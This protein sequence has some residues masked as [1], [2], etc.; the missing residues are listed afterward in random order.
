MEIY[1]A[2]IRGIEGQL[3]RFTAVK[4]VERRNVTLLG[5]AQ[6]VVR[7]GFQRAAKA[8]ETLEGEWSSILSNQGYTIQLSPAETP[9]TSSGLDLPIAIMLL[10]ASILQNLESL[11]SEIERLEKEVEKIGERE[12]RE[13]LKTQLLEEIDS[14]IRQRELIL[15]Y[16]KRLTG[17]KSRYLLIGTL[18]ITTGG[19]LTP[20]YGMFGM[21][22]CAKPGFDVVIPEES[23]VHGALISKARG[24]IRVIIAADLQEVWNVIL[25]LT[26]PRKAS[27][28][29]SQIKEKRL[30]HYVPDLKAIHGVALAKRAMVVA[31]AGGHNIL[32]LGPPGQGKSMLAQAATKLLPTLSHAEMFEVNKIYS[33]KGELQGNEVMLNRPFQEVT[34][35][36]GA[37]L[38]GGGSRPPLPGL[39]SLAHTGVLLFDEINLLPINLIQG[40]RNT[41]ND[42]I[43]KIQR[44]NTIIE[45]PCN[46]IMIA[47]MNPCEDGWYGHLICPQCGRIFF[48]SISE[49][50]EHPDLKLQSKCTCTNSKISRFREKLTQPLMDR[51]DLKVFLSPYDKGQDFEY[52]Y[53][54]S[55]VR[56]QIQA[57][58]DIQEERYKGEE[59]GVS[60]ACVPDR[61]QFERCTPPLDSNVKAFIEDTCRRLID[62]KR[63]EVKLLLVSRTISDL[64]GAKNI[65]IKDV[66]E[67]ISLMGLEHP[68]FRG[69]F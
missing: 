7:E 62:T 27:Y 64:D 50:P 38:F 39:V 34:R 61:S 18:D 37:A 36:T 41:M 58:R 43:Q 17:N 23:E 60:N 19:I 44:L 54:S 68:Y 52:D 6:R 56:K 8:I 13:R 3:I 32:L 65:R 5:L 21:I 51:I 47:A 46:F 16:R 48:S 10:Q 69:T 29:I 9:K 42:R 24:D 12:G 15:K 59:F 30:T 14:L 35:V 40:L 57:A 2:D 28:H 22:S 33:A 11:A 20:E 25:G 67:A 4:E 26:P 49:C 1:G 63:K 31:L 55:T 45:Y 53:A 66:K